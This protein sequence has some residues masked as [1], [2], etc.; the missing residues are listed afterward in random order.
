[1]PYWEL[2]FEVRAGVWRTDIGSFSNQ[3]EQGDQW[4]NK[5]GKGAPERGEGFVVWSITKRLWREGELGVGIWGWSKRSTWREGGL[6]LLCIEIV[7]V[8]LSFLYLWYWFR[9]FLKWVSTSSS[10]QHSY[11]LTYINIKLFFPSVFSLIILTILQSIDKHQAAEKIPQTR[12]HTVSQNPCSSMCVYVTM[13]ILFMERAATFSRISNISITHKR[14]QW[15]FYAITSL[16][17][18]CQLLR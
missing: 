10:P 16:G 7:A 8:N 9:N 13:W 14:S 5:A 17:F 4:L 15:Q 2:G 18:Y 6:R 11:V 12:V 1:M 3:Q